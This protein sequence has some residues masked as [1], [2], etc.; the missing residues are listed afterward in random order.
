MTD[1][2]LGMRMHSFGVVLHCMGERQERHWIAFLNEV[3]RAIGMSAVGDPAVWAYP[4]HGKGGTGQTFMLPITESFL[5][6]DTWPDHGG[7]YL[8]VCSCKPF[9]GAV[10]DNVAREFALTPAA[11][12]GGRFA[13]ELNLK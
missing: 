1:V 3:A 11:N 2:A 4:L 12:G 13:A 5:A 6:L 7:A 8:F 10:I 9:D